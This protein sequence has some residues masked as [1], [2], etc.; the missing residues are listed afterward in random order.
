MLLTLLSIGVVT[1]VEGVEI[2]GRF[3]GFLAVDLALQPCIDV[4]RRHFAMPGGDRY[5]AIRGNHVAPGKYA[6]GAGHQVFVHGDNAIIHGDARNGVKDAG[7]DVLPQCQHQAVCLQGFN[8]TG[9]L[10]PAVLIHFHHF[11]LEVGAV[12]LA[13]GAQPVDL[14]AFGLGFGGLEIM[15]RHIGAVAAVNDHGFFGAHALGCARGIHGGVA[16]TVNSD[17]AAQFGYVAFF[18]GRQVADGIQ[19]FSGITCRNVHMR[20]EVSAD[21]H[22]YGIEFFLL[23]GR[24]DVFDFTVQ[25][26]FHTQLLN[27][28][29]FR[30]Q[31]IAR[32]AIGGYAKAHHAPGHGPGFA[33]FHLMSKQ[34]EM[35]GCRQAR[36]PGAYHQNFLTAGLSRDLRH[37]AFLHRQITEKSLDRMDAH[38]IIHVLAVAGR[39]T[40]VIADA[41]VNGRHRVVPHQYFP[42]GFE[43]ACLCLVQPSLDILACGTGVVARWYGIDKNRL[44]MPEGAGA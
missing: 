11:H 30:I 40:G 19:N 17:P 13:N 26:D 36:R 7:I 29:D 8:F 5:G 22:E 10:W 37:P 20:G 18:H 32:H 1:Q 43:F 34:S 21:R 39:F 12:N 42:G 15:R 41:A 38:R 33:N 24:Q 6:C 44:L 9:R 14:D 2:D 27:A 4:T 3:P 16:A 28:C 31:H 35:P 25:A 23:L